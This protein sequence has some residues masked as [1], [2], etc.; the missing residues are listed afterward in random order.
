MNKKSIFLLILVLTSISACSKV[1][2]EEKLDLIFLT[3]K[4]V[5]Y[6]AV[7]HWKKDQEGF[8]SINGILNVGS[9]YMDIRLHTSEDRKFLIFETE[10]FKSIIYDIAN[11]S[12][13]QEVPYYFDFDFNTSTQDLYYIEWA[14]DSF[15]KRVGSSGSSILTEAGNN[16]TCVRYY[17]QNNSILASR[18]GKIREINSTTGLVLSESTDIGVAKFSVY[19]NYIVYISNNKVCVYNLTEKVKYELPESEGA[20]SAAISPDF[21]RVA[22]CRYT[23]GYRDIVTSDLD[24]KKRYEITKD[25]IKKDNINKGGSDETP[26]WY[27]ENWLTYGNGKIV[28]IKDKAKLRTKKICDS[29]MA[30]CYGFPIVIK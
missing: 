2:R 22:Y 25:Y 17:L 9:L 27:D 4:D 8:S 20:V 13:V 6:G 11:A 24:G 30:R 10:N 7:Y 29:E 18:E 19:G 1:K 3:T 14:G 12:I 26:F 15:I 16:I 23:E 5:K 21:K 28:L